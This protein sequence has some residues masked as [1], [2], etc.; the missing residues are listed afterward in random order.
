MK[1]EELLKARG[2]TDEDLKAQES[3][4]ANPKF[5]MALE[6]E[7]GVIS[8]KATDAEAALQ[9]E[10]DTWAKW[11]QETAIPTIDQYQKDT[12]EAKAEAASWKARYD[13]AVKQGYVPKVDGQPPADPKATPAAT[14]PF[15]PKKHNLATAEDLGKF[16]ST[17]GEVIAMEGDLAEEYFAL[18]GQRLFDYSTTLS[19]GRVLHGRQAL[20]HEAG[21]KK[22]QTPQQFYDFVAQKFDFAGK[23]KAAADKRQQEA[24]AAIRA[25]ERS[26]VAAEFGNPALRAPMPSRFP[27]VPPKPKADGQPWEQTPSQLRERRVAHAWETETKARTQ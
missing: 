26:K 12:V 6:E 7:Y 23:R 16:A 25:D 9:A 17:Q 10:K 4:L 21:Q 19:D 15:D 5:R 18:T 27:F 3:L 8:K 20:R 24:E 11:H 13:E 2:W 1:L 22:I 14:D